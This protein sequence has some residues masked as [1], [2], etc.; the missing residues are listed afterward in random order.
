MEEQQIRRSLETRVSGPDVA[1]DSAAVPAALP[2]A[3]AVPVNAVSDAAVA[4]LTVDALFPRLVNA[5]PMAYL[6]RE[7]TGTIVDDLDTPAAVA[8]LADA[9]RLE[10]YAAAMKASLS[11]RIGQT[12]LDEMPDRA[13]N[14]VS[15]QSLAYNTAVSEIGCALHLAERTAGFLL[16][17][18][19]TLIENFPATFA[20]LTCG[21]LD[22]QR[23]RTILAQAEG[24]PLQ[25]LPQYETA[26]LTRAKEQNNPQVAARARR[27]RETLHPEA[28]ITRKTKAAAGRSLTFRPAQDGM[29]YLEAF[30]PAE[31]ALAAYNTITE[32]AQKAQGP[33]EPR[34]LSQLRADLTAAYLLGLTCPH[35]T[36]DSASRDSA[37]RDRTDGDE[38]HGPRRDTHG[39]GHGRGSRAGV[40]K[41][42]AQIMI[43]IP[44]FS[45]LG[46][47]DE[48]AELAGYGPMPIETALDLAKDEPAWYRMLTDPVTNIPAKQD[49]NLYKIPQKTRTWLQIRDG[50]CR[51]PGCTRQ[52]RF[53]DTD[54]TIPWPNGPSHIENLAC[55][56][57]RHHK[58]KHKMGWKVSQTGNGILTW[59]APSHQ[60]YTTHPKD[61]R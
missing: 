29:A 15:G 13:R 57:K 61:T 26:V 14:T 55:L 60:T 41:P 38:D 10:S 36:T 50:T 23:V 48:A 8:A 31:T 44:L 22:Y 47:K 6:A 51:F 18:S 3:A 49:R 53:T 54:H 58:L 37:S 33:D 39:S 11:V 21:D 42:K 43:M 4:A 12:V 7:L 25:T 24:I 52:A 16:N 35:T 17:D 27:L 46:I 28:F 34:T 32:A 45:L 56:C 9:A 20:A 59:T 2:D 19:T 1:S 40:P 30:L 5:H